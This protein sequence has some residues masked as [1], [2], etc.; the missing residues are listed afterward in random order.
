MYLQFISLKT[1]PILKK[2]INL[3]IV[4]KV[5]ILGW[6]NL[7]CFSSK[8]NDHCF[9]TGSLFYIFNLC[10]IKRSNKIFTHV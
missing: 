3:K 9:K 7:M 5:I 4:I 2:K 1:L 10:L 6:K 8:N